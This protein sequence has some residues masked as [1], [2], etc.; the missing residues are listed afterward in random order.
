M[1][2]VVLMLMSLAC[3][4]YNG[5]A[6]A[7]EAGGVPGS[8]R[9][10]EQIARWFSSEFKYQMTLPDSPQSPGETIARRT[11]DCDDF[12]VLAAEILARSGIPSDVIIIKYEGLGMMHA[13]CIFKD[14]DGTYSFIS[15]MEYHRT[16]MHDVA[17][18]VA[19]YYPD[20]ENII[21][22]N[23]KREFLKTVAA[24]R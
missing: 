13:I 17:G 7:Q 14:K 15:N 18:A 2:R 19:K 10:P 12:A 24:A 1:K 8:V 11:G 20:Y 9:T 22:S 5:P 16:H 4:L 3:L 6:F 23:G 21:Y